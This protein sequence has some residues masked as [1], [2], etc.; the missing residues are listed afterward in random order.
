MTLDSTEKKEVLGENVIDATPPTGYE[1]QVFGGFFSFLAY[2]VKNCSI[3]TTFLLWVDVRVTR[4]SGLFVV[5]CYHYSFISSV[6][7]FPR[8]R[9]D[10]IKTIAIAAKPIPAPQGLLLPNAVATRTDMII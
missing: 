7:L 6:T 1:A 5:T 8:K 3:L 10:R 4:A 2:F 9:G